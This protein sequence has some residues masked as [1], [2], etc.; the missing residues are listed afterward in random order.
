[1]EPSGV[2]LC[3]VMSVSAECA[4]GKFER[5]FDLQDDVQ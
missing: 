1:M 4:L 3:V 2:V 5:T